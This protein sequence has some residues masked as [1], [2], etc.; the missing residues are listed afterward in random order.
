MHPPVVA[1]LFLCEGYRGCLLLLARVEPEGAGG[2][3]SGGVGSNLRHIEES[4]LFPFE[5]D[6]LLLT[7]LILL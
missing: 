5:L 2:H 4:F 3:W 1:L 6:W 7:N